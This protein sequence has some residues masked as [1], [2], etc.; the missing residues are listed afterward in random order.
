MAKKVRLDH[1]C[2][3][4]THLFLK[5]CSHQLFTFCFVSCFLQSG[6][7]VFFYMGKSFWCNNNLLSHQHCL[8]FFS[9]RFV[10]CSFILFWCFGK[11]FL[12]N[13]NF[14]LFSFLTVKDLTNV[15]CFFS[16]AAEKKRECGKLP[17]KYQ[18]GSSLPK[19]TNLVEVAFFLTSWRIPVTKLLKTCFWISTPC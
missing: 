9:W 14:C 11:N 15:S 3:P 6:L 12:L 13:F 8:K 2:L 17:P 1:L 4:L 19:S 16:S 5:N 10:F 18:I 7:V